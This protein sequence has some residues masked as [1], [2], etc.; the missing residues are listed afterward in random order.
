MMHAVARLPDVM[1]LAAW[2]YWQQTLVKVLVV[3][4][5]VPTSTALI[6]QTFLFKTMAHMQSR[7]GPMEA[8]PHG[9]LQLLA[10]GAKFMQKELVTPERADRRVFFLAPIVVLISTF[11]VFVIIPAGPALIGENLDTGIFF[12]LA[13]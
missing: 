7:L 3:L 1:P 2:A 10:D 11:M 13:V 5:V 9:S 6:V 12:A 8:G 4:V